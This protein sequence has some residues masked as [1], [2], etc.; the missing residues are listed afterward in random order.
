M[1]IL[2]KTLILLL[3]ASSQVLAENQPPP[4]EDLQRGT[5]AQLD[6]NDDRLEKITQIPEIAAAIQI[7][8]LK[9]INP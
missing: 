4:K 7:Q 3:L 5:T 9:K 1:R 6:D 8:K 2:F